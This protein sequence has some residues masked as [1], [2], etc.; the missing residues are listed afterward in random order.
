MEGAKKLS[1]VLPN[2]MGYHVV[3][4]PEW[5]HIDFAFSNHVR[6]LV[7]NQLISELNCFKNFTATE[8]K[9]E[10]SSQTSSNMSWWQ[11]FTK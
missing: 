1:E 5:N 11:L 6:G 7:F 4:K 9:A 10:L 2:S 8:C 3:E